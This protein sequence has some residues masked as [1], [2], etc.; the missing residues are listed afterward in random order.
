[1]SFKSKINHYRRTI[2]K[3]FTGNVQNSESYQKIPYQNLK[4]DRV[5]IS[6]PN[7]RLGNTLL[8]T[9]LVQELVNFNPNITIDLFVKGGVSHVV[10]ENYPQINQIIKLPRKPFKELVDYVKVWIKVRSK[11]YDLVIN[12]HEESASGRISTKVARSK[13]KL[14]GNEFLTDLNSNEQVHLGKMPVYQFRKFIENLTDHKIESE[15]PK[16]DLKLSK[17]EIEYGK[18]VLSDLIQDP[19]KK[20]LAFF[21][22]A[23]GSKCYVSDWWDKFYVDFKEEFDQE[24]NLI[25]ILP[26]ENISMLNHKLPAFYSQDIREIAAVMDNCDL[27]VAGDSG[28]MH[29][30]C[31]TST[32]NLGLFKSGNTEKYKPY[33][34]GNTMALVTDISS[35]GLVDKMKE[36]LKNQN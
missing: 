1:M 7:Q 22:Y 20:T 32:R 17:D 25:E 19:S 13:Y 24:Y 36:I 10:F 29:L 6:R 3:S 30:G 18:G 15:Y 11:Q 23:T 2:M 33:G 35:E 34:K 9:P 12:V 27:L 28:M 21:T 16:L 26:V 8:I 31:A 4:I 5:L 14:F